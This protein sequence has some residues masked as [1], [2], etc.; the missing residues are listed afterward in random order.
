MR[1][2]NIWTD[3]GCL[4]NQES[5]KS[6]AK[7]YGSYQIDSNPPVHF[8]LPDYSTNNEAEYVALIR[9]VRAVAKECEPR[10]SLVIHTDSELILHQIKGQWKCKARNLQVLRD[11]ARTELKRLSCAYEIVHVDRSII[12]SHLGH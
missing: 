9:G 11:K 7:A 5:D 2:I 4:G 8:D 1:T 12:V 3:G 6:K 10:D